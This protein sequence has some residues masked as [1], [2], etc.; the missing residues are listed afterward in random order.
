MSKNLTR[1]G[2]AFGAIVALGSSLIAGTPANAVGLDT[3]AV[4]LAPSTG[5]EYSVLLGQSFS[6]KS[7]S[8]SSVTGTG[9]NLKFY[10]ADSASAAS[11]T[12]ANSD[13]Y[14]LAL[15]EASM[16]A[17][18]AG[19][20]TVVT[21][22][23][24]G[25]KTGDLV[26]ISG[27][28]SALATPVAADATL[29]NKSNAVITVVNATTFTYSTASALS[30][31]YVATE[32]GGT[33]LAT[34]Q[35]S[36][37]AASGNFV[38]D[39]HIDVNTANRTLV[40]TS[41]TT[42][43]VSV[44]VTAWVDDNGDNVI[45]STEYVSPTRTVKFLA[46][47]DITPTVTLSPVSAGDANLTASIT[48]SPVLNGQQVGD[49][50]GAVFNRQDASESIAVLGASAWSDTTKTWTISKSLTTDNTNGNLYGTGATG[51][52]GKWTSFTRPTGKNV[53]AAS[54]KISS[55]VLT[56]T[57]ASAH[58]LRVG[59]KVTITG[60]TQTAVN[61]Q[62]TVSTIPSTTTFTAALTATDV[63][64]LTTSGTI[65]YTV[66]TYGSGVSLTDRAFPGTYSAQ[67]AVFTAANI[68]QTT[69]AYLTKIGSAVSN[70]SAAKTVS[71]IA[72]GVS[73]NANVAKTG[74][75]T[76]DVRKA[77]TE[78]T[79]V[80]TLT[81]SAATAVGAGVQVS[82]TVSGLS[83]AGTVKVN[84]VTVAN[85]SVVYTTTDAAG[86]ANFVVTN[87]SGVVGEAVT[88][89]IASEGVSGANTEVLTWAAPAF[90]IV[91]LSDTAS[92]QGVI[93]RLATGSSYTYNV[94]VMD[95]FKALAGDNIRIKQTLA[96]RTQ[97]V[98]YQPL[99]AGKATLVITDGGLT[100]DA[101]T[102]VSFE[103]EEKS[104]AGV[105]SSHNSGAN[106]WSSA[107]LD[108]SVVT[109]KS[110]TAAA[111][112]IALNADGASTPNTATAADL[113]ATATATELAAQD[114]R[115][116][117]GNAATFVATDAAVVSGL[118]KNSVTAA[119]LAGQV[120]TIN[121]T[122]LLFHAGDVW[123]LGSI[124]VL[125]NANGFFSVEVYSALA[126]EKSVTVT[127]GA[128]SKTATIT[129]TGLGAGKTNKLSASAAVVSGQSGRT[130][131]FTATVVDKLGNPVSG[132]ALKA[133]LAGI[134][135]FASSTA[136]D[137]SL[138]VTT[139]VNGKAVVRVNVLAGDTGTATVTFA[140]NDAS[141]ATADNIASASA[142]TEFA[143]PSAKVAT[144]TV[145]AATTS[146]AGRALDVTVKAVDAAGAAV[147][148]AVVALSS[149]GAGSL[150]ATSV[151]TNASGVATVKLV[152]GLSDVGAAVVTATS[153]AKSGS[154]TVE[155]GATDATVDIIGKRVYVTTEFA[156]GKRVTIYDNGVRR[157]SAIQTT[158]AEK[159]VMWNVKAGSHTIVVKISGASS[160]SVTFLVK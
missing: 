149:T 30:S 1:K 10:V 157:Y 143:D 145:T 46:S 101:F 43:T 48:T 106:D 131:D 9:K 23:A 84:G 40:L 33:G 6:L 64:P 144:V 17:T 113:A 45:D 32:I 116:V 107:G 24:N 112:A 38:Y 11:V 53:T 26:T 60:A 85:T 16:T 41:T 150:A 72:V 136:A 90:R 19:V 124:N 49:K 126:G 159:V 56:I 66:T 91:D 120:V 100:T 109:W 18:A 98:S 44:D 139:D 12:A 160:D 153:N 65:A 27:L 28:T 132:F 47:S 57:A 142:S 5:T 25:L 73:V 104:T 129:Y 52:D 15:T 37:R 31:A 36:S 141:T 93:A 51:T 133:T 34:Y 13:Q 137:G 59:D 130:I 79:V 50:V 152:A 87:S 22:S 35:R 62:V 95:Q 69:A 54:S 117:A 39:S 89:T 151:V 99:T 114:L 134:G 42:A 123:S 135:Y 75:G 8:A 148:G 71:A 61:A 55:N 138:A 155:F 70:G 20:V 105:W 58:G 3:G 103:L 92:T 115:Q 86:K 122:G 118:L 158:D 76:A 128:V 82:A 68:G 121:G 125:S 97:S 80:A 147:A 108:A 21:T 127:S 154:A 140:D 2:L 78:A 14:Q 29:M 77:T 156:A 67:A 4:S 74:T 81:T 94:V 119:A 102:T 111:D 96:N 88:L 146:Q 83:S 7:N 110:A 63:D